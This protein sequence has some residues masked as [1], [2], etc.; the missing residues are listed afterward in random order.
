MTICKALQHCS[1]SGWWGH[2]RAPNQAGVH[3]HGTRASSQPGRPRA[4]ESPPRDMAGMDTPS[5]ER[6]FQLCSSQSGCRQRMRDTWW[7]GCLNTW[8][9]FSIATQRAPE[10]KPGGF[11]VIKHLVSLVHPRILLNIKTGARQQCHC[12]RR[13]DRGT[14]SSHILINQRVIKY[15]AQMDTTAPCLKLSTRSHNAAWACQ[16]YI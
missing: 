11:H 15:T 4:R 7:E 16:T 13:G 6:R 3:S 1:Q 2:C 5:R 12:S 9:G 10:T 8:V 14:T